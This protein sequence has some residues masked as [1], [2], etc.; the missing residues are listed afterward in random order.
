MNEIEPTAEKPAPTRQQVV[1]GFKKFVDRG[2]ANPDDLPLDDPQVATANAI[3]DAWCQQAEARV[4]QNR[5]PEANLE[6]SLSRS[7]VLTD[8]GF[9]DPDYLDEVAN[10][11]LVQDLQRAED[12]GLT[13]VAHKIQAKMDELDVKRVA[14]PE[15]AQDGKPSIEQI[16]VVCSEIL[17]SDALAGLKELE[18]DPEDFLMAVIAEIDDDDDIEVNAVSFLIE[19]GLLE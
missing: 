7:T 15:Q 14:N 12:A 19:K 5:S 9:S 1:D 10:D 4:K 8:A 11:W 13:E 16:C 6:F 3:L 2:I 17:S 18:L